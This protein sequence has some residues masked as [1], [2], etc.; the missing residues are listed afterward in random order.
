GVWG[1]GQKA[2]GRRASHC[3]P[4]VNNQPGREAVAGTPAATVCLPGPSCTTMQSPQ[5]ASKGGM[6]IRRP[7]EGGREG[8]GGEREEE[9]RSLPNCHVNT[10]V[11]TQQ[12][13]T[14]SV[15]RGQKN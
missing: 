10:N 2:Q 15:Q 11:D 3:H 4:S 7:R 13:L 1:G 8:E 9:N 14:A 12:T 6:H 5:P